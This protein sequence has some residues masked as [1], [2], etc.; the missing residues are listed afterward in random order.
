MQEIQE[1]LQD[2]KDRIGFK[3]QRCLAAENI[4]DY[5]KCDHLCEQ[6]KSLRAEVRELE[7]EYKNLKEKR[8]NQSGIVKG[9]QL[10]EAY[11]LMRNN[12]G[13]SKRK[14]GRRNLHHLKVILHILRVAQAN[15]LLH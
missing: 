3:E 10:L 6:I 13:H 2:I 15:H 11:H 8:A 5:T 14:G 12:H 1:D 9:C 7:A 4:R